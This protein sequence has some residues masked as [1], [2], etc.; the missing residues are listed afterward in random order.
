MRRKERTYWELVDGRRCRL[1]VFAV[2]VG[3]RWDKKARSFIHSLAEARARTA[4]P[5]LRRSAAL[6]WQRRWTGI[7][8]VAAQTAFAA[9]L[10]EEPLLGH[11]LCD[12]VAPPLAEV[13]HDG[14]AAEPPSISRM[15]APVA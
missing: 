7:L 10:L 8:A 3:G 1:E 12:G 11:D 6:A 14:A 15:G 13:L 2:E 5:L 4:P 9:S